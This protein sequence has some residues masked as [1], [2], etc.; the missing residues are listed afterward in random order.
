M[1]RSYTANGLF[2]AVYAIEG[3]KKEEGRTN[4][5]RVKDLYETKYDPIDEMFVA[6]KKENFND[7]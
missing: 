2:D 6:V 7:C 1:I 5:Q 3:W 4:I